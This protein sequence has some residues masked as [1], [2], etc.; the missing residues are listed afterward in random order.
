V[1]VIA[2]QFPGGHLAAEALRIG[3]A[4]IQA[5]STED[6]EFEFSDPKLLHLL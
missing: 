2:G 5:L 6:G 1:L 3:D 4:P